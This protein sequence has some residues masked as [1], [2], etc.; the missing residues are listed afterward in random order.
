[1]PPQV[2]HLPRRDAKVATKSDV[3]VVGAGPAGTAAAVSAARNGASVTLVE[4][5]G[6]MGGLASGGMVLVLDD[7]MN[8]GSETVVHGIVDEFITRMVALGKAVY[9]PAGEWGSN[10]AHIRTWARWGFE[11]HYKKG[12]TKPILYA[13]AFDPEGWKDVSNALILES[14]VDL[15]LHSWFSTSVIEDGRIRGVVVETKQGPQAI[16]GDVVIDASGDADVAVSAGAEYAESNFLVTTVFRLGGVDTETA[17]HF[18]SEEPQRA[19]DINR[20]AIRIL[21]GAW[22]LWWL[23]TPLP[24]IVW[25]NCPHMGGYKATD[26]VSLTAAQFDGRRR[27]SRLV[28]YVREQYPGFES[29][30]LVDVASQIGVRQSRMIVGEYVVTRKDVTERRHFPD[31]VARG[32]DYYTPYRSLVP[33]GV[34]QLLV[35]GRHYSATPGAQR[36]SREIPPCMAMGEAAGVAAVQALDADVTVRDVDVHK[37]QVAL[38][39]QGA[40]PG[41]VPSSNATLTR[42][43][44]LAAHEKGQEL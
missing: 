39:K 34:E 33:L 30:F 35:V 6:V 36:I 43:P 24:G 7:L 25:C 15:R 28:A 31:S 12:A 2:V 11:D 42:G 16:L 5:Y 9:P 1:M 21:G 38:R 4:R 20:E 19:F 41:D 29:A 10:A 37:V 27:I 40:D 3:V 22:P 32:R 14:G 17:E 13:V 8:N 26:P 44:D 23:K 18:E